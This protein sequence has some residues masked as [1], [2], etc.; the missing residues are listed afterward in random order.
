MLARRLT[1]ILPTMIPPEAIE[2]TRIHRLAGRT[3]P[4]TALVPARPLPR[5]AS[6]A[7]ACVRP[8]TRLLHPHEF[9]SLLTLMARAAAKREDVSPSRAFREADDLAQP[10]NGLCTLIGGVRGRWRFIIG[11]GVP[12]RTASR[13]A[14]P[15]A[16]DSPREPADSLDDSDVEERSE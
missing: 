3:G 11:G 2:T 14:V 5:P 13:N 12:M 10:R 1:M 15:A 8:G 16:E 9:P 4:R 6:S 7:R